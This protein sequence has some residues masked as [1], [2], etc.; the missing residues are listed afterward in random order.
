MN[1]TDWGNIRGARINKALIDLLRKRI[2]EEDY[3]SIREQN[4]EEYMAERRVRSQEVSRTMPTSRDPATG[5]GV[6]DHGVVDVRRLLDAGPAFEDI[7]N[8]DHRVKAK[9]PAASEAA[10][11]KIKT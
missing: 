7:K 3:K 11:L 8:R 9:K 10:G 6:K 5:H 1:Q 4:Y 2:S